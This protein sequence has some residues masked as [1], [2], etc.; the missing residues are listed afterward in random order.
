MTKEKAKS[1][2]NNKQKLIWIWVKWMSFKNLQ[3]CTSTSNN[4]SKLIK[5][6]KLHSPSGKTL[7]AQI[8]TVKTREILRHPI[9]RI[10]LL[11]LFQT[12]LILHQKTN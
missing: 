8:H 6:I 7:R 2:N 5:Q 10:S 11:F 4:K 1:L 9:M 12:K 3:M